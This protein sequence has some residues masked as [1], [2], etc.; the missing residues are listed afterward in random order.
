LHEA[1]IIAEL[2][3]VISSQAALHGMR[4]VTGLKMKVGAMRAAVP[5]LL[6]SA[7]EVMRV[8]TIAEKATLEIDPVPLIARCKIC[9][10]DVAIEEFVFLCPNCQSVLEE[11]VSGKE[12]DLI[13]LEG[14]TFA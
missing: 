1:S 8:G 3:E 9:K 5:A 4:Q 12:M 13:E 2:L 11:I 10:K 7:F 14:E 6:Q